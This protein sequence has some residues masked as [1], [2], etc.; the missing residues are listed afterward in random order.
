VNGNEETSNDGVV[1]MERVEFKRCW[2]GVV[3]RKRK[4]GWNSNW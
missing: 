4:S 3:H 2:C 1:V